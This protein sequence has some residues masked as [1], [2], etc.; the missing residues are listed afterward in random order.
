MEVYSRA[1]SGI[2][3]AWNLDRR[4]LNPVIFS[5]MCATLRHRG[6]DGEGRRTTES[7]GFACQHFWVTPEEVGE[8]QPLVGRPGVMIVMDG[9]LD[10]RGDLMFALGVSHRAS[11]AA[12]VLA[13]YDGW[14]DRFAE[15]L[16]GDF[17]LAIFDESKRQLLL[18][19]DAIGI[20]PLYYFRSERLFA[21]ASEIKALLAHPGIPTRVDDEGLADFLIVGNRPDERHDIT[22]FAG[23]STLP[24][25]HVATVSPERIIVRR[26][27]DFDTAHGLR[28]RSYSAYV[29]AFHERFAEAV[30]RRARTAYPVAVSVS[31]GL[32]SSSVFCQAHV[33]QRAGRVTCPG[34]AGISY[35]GADG[36][37][38]DERR[39]LAEIEREHGVWIERFPIDSFIGLV[40]GVEEQVLAMEAP[41]FDYMWALTSELHRRAVARGARVLLSGVWGDQVLFSSAYLVDLFMRGAWRELRRHTRA[42][43][44][45][46]GRTEA[47]VLTRRF[48]T[49]L[50]RYQLPRPVLARLKW[51]RRRC[52][53]DP[54]RKAWFSDA[55]LRH[56]LRLGDR[57]VFLGGGFH[58]AQAR[59]I[60]FEARSKY[61]VRCMELNNKAC[62][63]HA[64]AAAFPLLDRDLLALLIATPG[65]VQNREGVPRALLREAMRGILPEAIRTRRGKAD[66]TAPINAGVAQAAPTI[67]DALTADPLGVRLGYLD[68]ARLAPEMARL[69]AELAGP[70]CA[71]S[72]DLADVFGLEVWL[73]V[74]LAGRAARSLG[75]Q[76]SAG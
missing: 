14:G 9:R 27:W 24:P 44:R 38:A 4:P 23:I 43:G 75:L 53:G 35:V 1:M 73:Q 71:N 2:I 63:A 64:L 5:D 65:E 67:L 19:R 32:D 15:H 28:F 59:S 11:D 68:A 16:N 12:C 39:Y 69:A 50:L 60:Y 58:S 41:L 10:N 13:A 52:V 61:H 8:L 22:L 3:G 6:S 49:D 76:E 57:P 54:R 70:D 72:W 62:A 51:I 26:Y 55:F 56:T 34:I 18:A 42:Y 45:W 17:A 47:R 31:G 74:F 20:R 48:A 40:D 36:T 29:E 25:A 21:F 66:F 33:L 37:D 30:R 46:L 7:L